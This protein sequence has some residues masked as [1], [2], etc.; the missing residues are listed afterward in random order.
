MCEVN[1]YVM[2][3]NALCILAMLERET[4]K[5]RKSSQ[6]H[7]T[8]K[9]YNVICSV[10]IH[11]W[12]V[13]LWFWNWISD[14]YSL[15]NRKCCL[16]DSHRIVSYRGYRC[17]ARLPLLQLFLLRVGVWVYVLTLSFQCEIHFQDCL[18]DWTQTSHISNRTEQK[19]KENQCANQL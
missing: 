19:K 6:N 16:T 11:G 10:H 15:K 1:R 18:M 7:K 2:E 8:H 5:K 14:L 3:V 13:K 9:S 17:I 12:L 4:A